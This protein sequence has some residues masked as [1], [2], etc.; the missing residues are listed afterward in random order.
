MEI[1]IN[2]PA[3]FLNRVK[4]EEKSFIKLYFKTDEKIAHRIRQN[5]WIM[6][7][8]EL[9]SWYIAAKKFQLKKTIEYLMHGYTV[10]ISSELKI[11]DLQL[12][13]MLLEQ[14]YKK[15]RYFKSCPMEFLE[16]MQL[17]NYSRS[18]FDTYHNMV[19]RF[20]NTFKG[21]NIKRINEFGVKEI[22]NYHKIWMQ[23]NAPSASLINQS[24]NAIKL[25]FRVI[26]RQELNKT[27]RRN[28]KILKQFN[29]EGK[30]T[31]RT[32]YLK[33][34]DFDFRYFTHTF[35]TKNNNE[36]RF[37]Y[38]YGYLKIDE[39]KTLIVNWQPYMVS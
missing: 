33:R 2:K 28:R 19:L 30:T 38:E 18:T 34:L 7:S 39:E 26:S 11:S 37:C 36:Y 14:S 4:L 16:Y 6:Y 35:T 22:D 25:Y 31:I 24:V 20:I 29:P 9:R 17:H 12:R 32:E 3:I 21:H 13:R 23:K 10:K 1:K 5:D 8:V 27:L 15:D